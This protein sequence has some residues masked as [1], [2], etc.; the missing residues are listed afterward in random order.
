MLAWEMNRVAIIVIVIV[1][2]AV[3]GTQLPALVRVLTESYYRR[4][5]GYGPA[6][7]A[8]EPG[9][10][11]GAGAEDAGEAQRGDGGGRRR[12]D[13]GDEGPPPMQQ[14]G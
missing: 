3:A 14:S 2:I 7:E 1:V 11:G 9:R 6:P 12:P 10:S 5:D 8:G 13:E 4:R